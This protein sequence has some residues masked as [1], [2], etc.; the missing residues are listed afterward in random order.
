MRRVKPCMPILKL[1]LLLA[2]G[3]VYG[4]SVGPD[5]SIYREIERRTDEEVA[6]VIAWR[7]D[8]HQHP[9]LGNREVRTSQLVADHLRKLGFKVVTGVGKTGVV[10]V[11]EGSAPGRVVA[12]RADMDALPVEEEVDLPFAS[13]VRDV[14]DGHEVGVMHA[15]GHDAHTAILMGTAEVLAGLRTRLPGTV[16]FLFQPAEEGPPAGEEGGAELMIK[17]GAMNDP[18]P[19]VIFGLHV[20]QSLSTG[21]V[22]TRPRG[23]MAGAATFEIKV[24]GRQTHGAE[25]WRGV[26]PI[27]VASQIILGIQTIVSRQ[28]ESTLAP[29]V[30]TVGSLHGGVRFNIIPDEVVMKGTTRTFEPSMA[31][32]LHARLEQTAVKIAESAGARAEVSIE[33]YSPVVFNDPE[34]VR[35]MLP[36]LERVYGSENVLEVQPV[37]TA[38]DFSLYQQQVPGMFFFVGVRPRGVPEEEMVPNH[39]P[40]FFVDEEAIPMAVKAMANLVVDYLQQE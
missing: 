11:L 39:S 21:Q 16:K 38:E 40:R 18:A 7:R 17:E 23:L 6:Q 9:E 33:G 30:I 14:Y 28:L 13:R 22:G 19:D 34:L 36:T 4:Q 20:F 29:A 1:C 26:D 37:T 31:A 32:D 2:G 3:S 27:V 24:T 25:P 12:L 5:Q 8:I 15:C 10:G 35:R